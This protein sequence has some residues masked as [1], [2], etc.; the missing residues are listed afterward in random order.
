[1]HRI[2]IDIGSLGP[3]DMSR[4]LVLGPHSLVCQ[5]GYALVD[6]FGQTCHAP[7][8]LDDNANVAGLGEAT[9][10][11]GRPIGPSSPHIAKAPLSNDAG[12]VSAVP[13]AFEA[14]GGNHA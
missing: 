11:R 13:I 6:H 2:G 10:A 9:A 4:D 5:D 14:D 12:L 8:F 3:L 1:M 7:V